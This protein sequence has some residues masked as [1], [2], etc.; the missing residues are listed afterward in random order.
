MNNKIIKLNE[1]DLES[2]SGG[3]TAKQVAKKTASCAVKGGLAGLFGMVG[4]ICGVLLSDKL[5]IS[6]MIEKKIF[7]ER[8][9][10]LCCLT[11]GTLVCSIPAM[12]AGISGWELGEWVCKKIG[13]ED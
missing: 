2:I 1:V 11:I 3:I 10:I 13:L 6:D 12:V 8:D 9:T 7:H 5:E 4:G